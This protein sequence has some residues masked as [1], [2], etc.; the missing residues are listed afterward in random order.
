MSIIP[1]NELIVDQKIIS[2][3]SSTIEKYKKPLFLVGPTGIGKTTLVLSLAESLN[4]KIT[5]ID[6]DSDFTKNKKSFFVKKEI[7]LLDNL[8]EV[9]GKKISEIV[10]YFV[11]DGRPLIIITSDVHKDLQKIK[12]KLKLRATNYNAFDFPSWLKYLEKKYPKFERKQLKHLVKQTRFNKGILINQLNI[13]LCSLNGYNLTKNMSMFVVFEN[14]FNKDA[15]RSDYYFRETM[16]PT[17]VFENYP[18]LKNNSIEFCSNTSSACAITDVMENYYKKKQ[19]YEFMP[20]VNTFTTEMATFNYN[21]KISYPR[22]PSYY[23]KTKKKIKDCDSL[24]LKR[25]LKSKRGKNY[26]KNE[27]EKYEDRLD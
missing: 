20:Y 14:V 7:I 23:S 18:K 16:L 11:K 4:Y 26:V 5:S 13:G 15:D 10:D 19:Y 6:P 3:V 24:D 17:F 12:Q 22:F 25:I 1:I 21:E 9:K 2:K 27:R 8:D